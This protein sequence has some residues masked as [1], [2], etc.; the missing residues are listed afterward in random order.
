ME[1]LESKDNIWDFTTMRAGFSP[2]KSEPLIS[3]NSHTNLN[4]VKKDSMGFL[5]LEPLGNSLETE[6][7]S[8]QNENESSY[9]S[10]KPEFTIPNARLLHGRNQLRTVTDSKQG[11]Q[12]GGWQGWG[13]T[14]SLSS[15]QSKDTCSIT[16]PT[17]SEGENLPIVSN[18]SEKN[19]EVD[20]DSISN[21]DLTYSRSYSHTSDASA[22]S[23][24]IY[25]P[26][27]ETTPRP[28]LKRTSGFSHTRSHSR[29][30]SRN[31]SI[32]IPGEIA[33]KPRTAQISIQ[34]L[35]NPLLDKM[36][37]VIKLLEQLETSLS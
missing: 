26:E 15:R 9:F 14:S 10:I 12:P 25:I 13:S 30:Q 4:T 35:P 5:D 6:L 17:Q 27:L 23:L 8:G 32:T 37:Y 7:N 34:K 20:D 1:Q 11:W 24:S 19:T 18:S 29:K 33:R 3:D 22:S 2:A 16:T 28:I 31:V 36:Q 21:S